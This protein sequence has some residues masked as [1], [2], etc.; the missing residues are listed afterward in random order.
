MRS[1][2]SRGILAVATAVANDDPLHFTHSARVRPLGPT[3]SDP[4]AT[5]VIQGRSGAVSGPD[6]EDVRSQTTISPP[7][8]AAETDLT[9]SKAPG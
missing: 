5:S 3:R 6:R 7:S 9:Y 4:G 1:S 8:L 2:R